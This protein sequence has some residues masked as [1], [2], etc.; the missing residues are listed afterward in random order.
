M[1][2][3]QSYAKAV[4]KKHEVGNHFEPVYSVL[5]TE[6]VEFEGRLVPKSVYVE[7]N[8]AEERKL[9]RAED[10]YLENLIAVGATGSLKPVSLDGSALSTVDNVVSQIEKIELNNAE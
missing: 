5:S 9:F 8:L 10:F 6:N 2:V 3:S 1:K 7:R 4:N